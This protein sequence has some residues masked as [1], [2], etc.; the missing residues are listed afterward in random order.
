[1]EMALIPVDP[2]T[3][4]LVQGIE[5]SPRVE[6]KWSNDLDLD[7]G[8]PE[9]LQLLLRWSLEAILPAMIGWEVEPS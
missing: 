8:P 7:R 4:Q 3:V 2:T 9:I 1:M 6:E 5:L